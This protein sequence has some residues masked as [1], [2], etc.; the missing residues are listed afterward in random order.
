MWGVLR[1]LRSGLLAWLFLSQIW[2]HNLMTQTS[3]FSCLEQRAVFSPLLLVCIFHILLCPR[4]S[5]RWLFVLVAVRTKIFNQ[6]A[7]YHLQ[8]QHEQGA[9]VDKFEPRHL[10]TQCWQFLQKFCNVKQGSFHRIVFASPCSMWQAV[11]VCS[12]WSAGL[13][14]KRKARAL[15]AFEPCHSCW[16]I[17]HLRQLKCP[18]LPSGASR[19]PSLNA[20]L[21]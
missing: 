21:N 10:I 11:R 13:T 12:K 18:H 9:N 1:S 19:W 15:H 14:T 16:S 8:P 17:L 20:T 3:N 4:V 5:W 2:F 6:F 7:L